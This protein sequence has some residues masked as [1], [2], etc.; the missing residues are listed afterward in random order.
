MCLTL[1][2]VS[3]VIAVIRLT[4]LLFLWLLVK[5]ELQ[6]N[7]DKELVNLIDHKTTTVFYSVCHPQESNAHIYKMLLHH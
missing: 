4:S 7:V 1:H 5:I 6:V 2:G 3:L